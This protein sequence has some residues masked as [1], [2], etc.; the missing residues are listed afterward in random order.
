MKTFVPLNYATAVMSLFA[1]LARCHWGSQRIGAGGGGDPNSGWSFSEPTGILK[2]SG[3]E[4]WKIQD[5]SHVQMS[6]C[7]GN[8]MFWDAFWAILASARPYTGIDFTLIASSNIYVSCH[9]NLF[10]RVRCP[11][12]S[13]VDSNG[14]AIQKGFEISACTLGRILGH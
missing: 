1:R 13:S 9:V 11:L 2:H 5:S 10:S 3:K 12:G 4:K 6:V 14:E 7:V 8:R